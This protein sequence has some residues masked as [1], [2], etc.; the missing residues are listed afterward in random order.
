MALADT[1]DR[2]RTRMTASES[3]RRA[4]LAVIDV[5]EQGFVDQVLPVGAAF[6]GFALPT[7][8]GRFLRSDT[9]LARGPLVVN[10]YRGDWCP[11]CRVTL[12]ALETALPDIER[13]G[14]TLLAVTPD[15]G[16][17][18]FA[19]KRTQGLHYELATDVDHALGLQT[20]VVFRLPEAYRAGLAANGIDLPR[21]QG[22]DGWLVPAPVTFVID[23]AGIVRWRHVTTDPTQRAEPAD[24]VMALA[25]VAAGR[26]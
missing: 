2:I 1:L 26:P 9:L 15:T 18:T 20:G 22:H 8:E 10:F 24:V 19:T 5:L 13:A 16:G 12:D 6:P 21:R 11:Y 14:A 3:G 25:A 7:A 17:R 23:Q 4:Y